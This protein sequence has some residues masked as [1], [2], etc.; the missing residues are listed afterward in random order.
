[1]A[2][3]VRTAMAQKL[4]CFPLYSWKN[5]SKDV[6]ENRLLFCLLQAL[7]VRTRKDAGVHGEDLGS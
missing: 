5:H 4:A 3:V 7:L 6:G 2:G 1:M